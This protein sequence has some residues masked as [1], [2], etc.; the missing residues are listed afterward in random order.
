LPVVVCEARPASVGTFSCRRN[1]MSYR[2]RYRPAYMG[3]FLLV[4]VMSAVVGVFAGDA[5][6]VHHA[7]AITFCV[8][9]VA[10]ALF[11]VAWGDRRRR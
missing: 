6:S 8:T 10:I 1:S 5:L 11:D 4:A 2:P 3:S 9:G 7:M